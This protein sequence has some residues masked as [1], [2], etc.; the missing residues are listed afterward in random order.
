MNF[1]FNK[2]L[3]EFLKNVSSD[4]NYW[5]PNGNL[6]IKFMEDVIDN[7]NDDINEENKNDV[8]MVETQIS[9]SENVQKPSIGLKSI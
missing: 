4:I 7:K 6:I 8:S 1:S 5:G 2:Y 3:N 9:L